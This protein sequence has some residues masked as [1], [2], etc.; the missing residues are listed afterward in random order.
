[1]GVPY[2]G[3]FGV[4]FRHYKGEG[5]LVATVPGDYTVGEV[6]EEAKSVLR[7]VLRTEVLKLLMVVTGEFIVNVWPASRRSN[8]YHDMGVPRKLQVVWLV[9]KMTHD[10]WFFETMIRKKGWDVR[11][12]ETRPSALSWLNAQDK[13][14]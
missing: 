12:C 2:E 13:D 8:L 5:L 9:K 3:Q 14:F 1:M 11:V 10:H 4:V 7:E 6:T